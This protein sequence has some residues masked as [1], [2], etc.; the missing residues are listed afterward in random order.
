MSAVATHSNSL[1]APARPGSFPFGNLGEYRRDGINLFIKAAREQG[2]VARIRFG[3]NTLYQVNHPDGVQHVLQSNNR[4]YGRESYANNI[5]QSVTGLNLFTSDGDYWLRQRRLMQPAFHRRR[6][7]NFGEIMT[8]ATHRMLD[9]WEPSIARGE[10]LDMHTEMMRITM[11]VVGRALFGVDLT[12][13]TSTLGKAFLTSTDY[14]NHRFS[15]P[16]DIPLWI[17]THRNRLVNQAIIDVRRILQGMIDERRRTGEQ[18]DDLLTMLMEARD[19]ETGETMDNEQVRIEAGII[20]GAGQETTSNLLTWTFHVLSDN[21]EIEARLL[22]ELDTALGGRTPKMDDLPNLPYLRMLV[23]EVLRVYPPAWAIS[24]RNA[25]EDDVILGYRIPKKS[26]VFI[27]P[28]IIHR[29]PRFWDRPDQIIPERFSDQNSAN[30]HRYAYIPFG[31]GPRKCIGNAFALAE[32]QLILATMLQKVRFVKTP[33][34]KVEP[35]LVFTLRV[36]GGLPMR[37]LPR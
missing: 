8:T 35:D 14:V 12:A 32:A 24:S 37:V 9:R 5:I 21:P 1:I 15:T 25:Y 30:R 18:K 16:F 34:Y 11:E 3:P 27:L 10:A 29:D 6:L 23:D 26:L 19:E 36:K 28:Y 4:N 2:D 31:A 13:E 7:E 17:P 33:G 22:A 20:I